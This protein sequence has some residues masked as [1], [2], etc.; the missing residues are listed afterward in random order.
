MA[1]IL[2]T[3]TGDNNIVPNSYDDFFRLEESSQLDNRKIHQLTADPE[4]AEL[5]LF[6]G[7]KDSDFGDVRTH[8]FTRQY[9][10][11]CFLYHS[12][13]LIFPFLP[14]VY[15]S[16]KSRNNW[17]QRA[18]PGGYSSVL[19]I[20]LPPF[21]F[22]PDSPY[23]FSFCGSFATH[24]SRRRLRQLIGAPKSLIIDTS[25]ELAQQAGGAHAPGWHRQR[26]A[27]IL[28][29]SQFVLCP[30]GRSPATWRLYETM[31][32][33]RVPVIIADEWLA[34]TLEYDWSAFSL[35]VSE[36]QVEKIT[37]LVAEYLP[38]APQMAALARQVYERYFSREVFFHHLVEQC[39]ALK[40]NRR[41]PERYARYLS[42]IPL[43]YPEN[44]RYFVLP[45]LKTLLTPKSHA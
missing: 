20:D 43:L 4:D 25:Q 6:I 15:P 24:P 21:P 28:Q 13:D 42:L 8:P 36:N 39:L 3:T 45:R 9:P 41:L 19:H 34:P 7:A 12:E 35:R 10:D 18:T 29:A 30:R 5:I 37:S 32:A 33:R 23:H 11:K 31:K 14:G 2:L 26:Y 40:V 44:I 17:F 38:Q 27:Q 22:N 16:L 1:K